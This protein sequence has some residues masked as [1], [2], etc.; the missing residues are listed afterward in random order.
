MSDPWTILGVDKNATDSDIKTAYRK[1]AQKHHP[2][3]DGGSADRFKEVNDAY[4]NIKDQDARQTWEASQVDPRQGFNPFA[5]RG[6]PFGNLHEIFRGGFGFHQQPQ[7]NRDI[8]I[9]YNISLQ[10]V[11]TG[12]KRT[13]NVNIGNNQ[14]LQLNLNVPRGVEHG[15]KIRF[16]GMGAHDISELP[17]GDLYV[18]IRILEHPRFKRFNRRDLITKVTINALEAAIGCEE[19]VSGLSGQEFSIKINKGTQPNT[20]LR[21]PEPGMPGRGGQRSGDLIIQVEI[22]V[23]ILSEEDL[24]LPLKDIL[25]K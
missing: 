24:E 20:K 18:I 5:N 17:K 11:Y 25:K 4:Q 19:F 8:Q 3:R 14:T 9:N 1:L 16:A 21:I 22:K 12:I 15:D 23:P 7:R 2:D 6:D 13:L 10:E